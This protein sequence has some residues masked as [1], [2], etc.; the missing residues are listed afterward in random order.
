VTQMPTRSLTRL[1]P[2][3]AVLLGLAGAAQADARTARLSLSLPSSANAGAVVRASGRAAG[4]PRGRRIVLQGLIGRRWHSVGSARVSHGRFKVPFIAPNVAGVLSVRAIL[5]RRRHRPLVSRVRRILIRVFH[6]RRPPPP[7]ALGAAGWGQN[8]HGELGAGYRNGFSTLPLSVRG[9]SGIESLVAGY[10]FSLALL[11]DGTVRSWGGNT[12]AQL[13]DG[14][15]AE[16]DALVPVA[17]LSGV[18]ALAAGGATAMA[19][20]SDGTVMTWGGNAY[21][22]LGNGTTGKGVENG[23]ASPIPIPVKGLS[24]V[25]AIAAGGADDVALLGNGTLMAWGENRNGQLGDGTTVE[26]DVPTP[27]RGLA[28]VKAVAM[29]GQSSHGGH[30]LALLMNG[31]V[32]AIGEN[33]SGQLGDGATTSSSAPVPVAGLSGVTAIAANVSHSMALLGDGTVRT[34]GGD[35]YGELGVGPAPQTCVGIPC[36]TLPVAVSLQH[37]TAISAGWR[38]S[39]ALSGG[40]VSSWGLN[41]LGQLGNG[42][43]TNSAVPVPVS[44]LGEVAGIAA[45]EQHSLALLRT[46]GLSAPLEIVPGV[47]SLTVSWKASEGTE[48]WYVS[49][50]PVAHPP[51][52]FGTPVTLPPT[53]RSYTISGLSTVPYEV[54]VTNKAFGRR[55]ITGTPLP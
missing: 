39:L 8:G 49:W 13:G 46:G 42:T 14:S 15:R 35:Q 45:G 23:T 11:G 33:Q 26:K 50:R 34:W 43:T 41:D 28:G 54:L 53:T 6:P 4:V 9:L 55:V 22:E 31:S 1:V 3:L 19:L 51:G 25:V 48:H 40:T 47:G 27:V 44:G 21:G 24:G 37:V 17:G 32:M 30:M 2:L 18:T 7:P 36:S 29:G 20:L 16:S 12:F 38:F 52:T 10:N 5:R